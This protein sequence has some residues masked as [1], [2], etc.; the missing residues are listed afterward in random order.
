MYSGEQFKIDYLDYNFDQLLLERNN[1]LISSN[2]K[3]LNWK[4][5]YIKDTFANYNKLTG[6]LKDFPNDNY[7]ITK[8]NNTTKYIYKYSNPTF[9]ES[10]NLEIK[11]LLVNQKKLY[12]HFIQF[13]EF[14]NV[15]NF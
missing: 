6:L 3:Y 9:V 4:N 10:L 8:V 5:M 12:K 15:S 1:P 2:E 14:L 7:S 13:I 11:T